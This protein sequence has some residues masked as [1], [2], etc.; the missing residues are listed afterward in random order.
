MRLLLVFASLLGFA[1]AQG[2]SIDGYVASES[3]IAKSNLLDNIGASGAKSH[4]AKAGIV[5]ASPSTS[6]PDYL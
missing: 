5:V 4:G 3:Q 2:S 1:W 6:N